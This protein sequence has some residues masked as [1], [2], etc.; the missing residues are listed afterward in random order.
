[1]KIKEWIEKAK[2]RFRGFGIKEWGI[3]LVI[4]ICCLIIVIPAQKEEDAENGQELSYEPKEETAVS[5]KGYAEQMEER[6]ETLLSCVEGVGTV[7]VMITVNATEEKRVL[8]DGKSEM[9]TV[10]ET[11]SA[12][13]TRESSSSGTDTETVFAEENGISTPYL[14]S[15]SYP[16]VV[17]VVVIAQGS[18]TGSVDYDILNAVQV[19]FDIPAHKI[20]IMK[21]K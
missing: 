2:E 19:L 10:S 16:E 21:M 17:G 3:L 9:E 18:G 4:G 8:Q 6:L 5:E 1:M 11:D 14:L 15:E 20:K 7:K 12:G 13:G